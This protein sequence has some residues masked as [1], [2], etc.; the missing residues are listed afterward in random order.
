LQ[1]NGFSGP[2]LRRRFKVPILLQHGETFSFNFNVPRTFNIV[3]AV[4]A[5]KYGLVARLDFWAT[6]SFVEKS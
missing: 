2:G 1:T 5:P 3:P 6:E 4:A